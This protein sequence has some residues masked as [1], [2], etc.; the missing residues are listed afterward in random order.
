MTLADFKTG[1]PPAEDVPLPE[2][3]AAQIALYARLVARIYPGRRVVPML[4]WT[5]GAVIRV[6]DEAAM[7]APSSAPASRT[8]AA[9]GTPRAIDSGMT[10]FPSGHAPAPGALTGRRA[11]ANSHLDR[12]GQNPPAAAG[13]LSG[14]EFER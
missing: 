5:S 1:R 10:D 9:V 7:E 8:E 6:L 4:V 2:A 14:S 12:A 13:V 3:E 11:M